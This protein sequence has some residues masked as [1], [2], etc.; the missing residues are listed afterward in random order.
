M[1]WIRQ[2][3]ILVALALAA[4]AH[5]DDAA[6]LAA[7]VRANSWPVEVTGN[8]LAG[9]GAQKIVTWSEEA[10]FFLLGEDHGSAGLARF[11]TALSRT[12]EGHGYRYT[13]VE[14]DPL[15][16]EQM[17]SLLSRGKPALAA[18]L[19]ADGRQL[20]IPF[21]SWSE[22]ADFVSASMRRGPIWGIDQSF[23]AA[24]PLHLDEIASARGARRC[25]LWLRALPR[26]PG[27]T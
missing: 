10:Q 4:P 15:M 8:G 24:A 23:I 26:K 25:G 19:G 12:L 7:L 13:V 18:W 14:V 3:A 9:P 11:A 27:R 1:R 16:T 2:G 5:A 17:I 20:A 6:D 22:E 21:Y